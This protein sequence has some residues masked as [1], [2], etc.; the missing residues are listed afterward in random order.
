[1]V[2]KPEK[3]EI[4]TFLLVYNIV[5]YRPVHYVQ[6]PVSEYGSIHSTLSFI[7]LILSADF[8]NSKF[9]NKPTLVHESRPNCSHVFVVSV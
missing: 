6:I 2:L 8:K 7:S 1:M 3:T 4:N 9:E 5:S